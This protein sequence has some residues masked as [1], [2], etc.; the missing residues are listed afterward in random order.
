V[1]VLPGLLVTNPKRMM[2]VPITKIVGYD[3]LIPAIFV[4]LKEAKKSE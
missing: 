2:Q 1:S 3:S 4:I